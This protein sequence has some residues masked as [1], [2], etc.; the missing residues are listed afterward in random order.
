MTKE[1][2]TLDENEESTLDENVK[3]EEAE[4]DFESLFADDET[5][6]DAPV[7]REEYNRLLKGTQKLATKYGELKSQP[8]EEVKETVKEVKEPNQHDDLSELFF[9]QI[10]N[11]EL[12]EDDLKIF[13]DAKYGGSILKAW[14]GEKTLRDKA[15]S[16]E[17]AKTQEETNKSKIDSPSNG[18]VSSKK[19]DVRKVEDKDVGK[20]TPAQKSEWL[21]HQVL[22]ERNSDM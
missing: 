17:N 19:V 6:E 22:K 21:K 13:A 16:L 12:V 4:D 8:K 1:E 18:I 5:Q 14:K 7:T 15:T 2:A 20:L 3:S 9:A 10:P 11:A